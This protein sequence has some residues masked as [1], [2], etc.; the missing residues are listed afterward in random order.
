MKNRS[1][2]FIVPL[3]AASALLADAAEYNPL[4]DARRPVA[5]TAAVPAAE[6]AK[7]MSLPPGF[8]AQVV[9]SEPDVVQPIGYSLDD[10]GRLWVVENTNYP[11]C[12]GVPKDKILILEDTDGDGR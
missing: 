3:L 4:E 7:K 2:L 10:R 9:A 8:S 5:T 6:A 11:E 12:P 1:S